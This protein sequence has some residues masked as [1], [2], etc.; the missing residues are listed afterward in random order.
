MQPRILRRR[1]HLWGKNS[2]MDGGM[3]YILVRA[4]NKGEAGTYAANAY[5]HP[6]N[7][8]AGSYFCEF[9][10]I[11]HKK[12]NEFEVEFRFGWDI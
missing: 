2:R 9:S 7:G 11:T 4:R 6:Y 8:R 1:E 5:L 10:N 3:Y 12:R